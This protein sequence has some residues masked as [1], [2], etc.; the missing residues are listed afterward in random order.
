ML[1]SCLYMMQN[2]LLSPYVIIALII[3]VIVLLITTF[4]LNR[5]L[6]SFTRGEN[7]KS[8]E[9]VIKKY[10]DEVDNLK[11]HDE[12][13]S[14]HALDLETRLSQCV[15]NISI[16]RFKAFE[17]GSTN[18]SFSIS[19]VNEKGDGVVI[20]SLHNRDRVS[21]FAKPITKYES[22]QELTDEEQQVL[23]DSKTANKRSKV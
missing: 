6:S 10:L 1:H 13:I 18:Q 20:T 19:L 2:I 22:T 9:D 23:H 11:K 3:C 8:L 15:R 21:T 12:L 4:S 16:S 5:K 14:Q 17:S 7:G